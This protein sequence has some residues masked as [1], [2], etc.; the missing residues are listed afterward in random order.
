MHRRQARNKFIILLAL[1]ALL[2]LGVLGRM[3]TRLHIGGSDWDMESF[4][5][6]YI[7]DLRFEPEEIDES[8]IYAISI[9]G[10]TGYASEP[11][12]V[13]ESQS[14][15]ARTE[16][17]ASTPAQPAKQETPQTAAQSGQQ[18]PQKAAKEVAPPAAEP[19]EPKPAEAQKK[20]TVLVHTVQS[21]ETLWDIAQAYGIT[22]DSIVSANDLTNPNRLRVGQK[23]EILTVKGVLHEVSA[24]ESL[25][26][27]AQRYKV[28]IDDI[29]EVN[30]IAD[31]SRIQPKTKLIIPGATRVLRSDAL[32]VNGQLQKAFDWPV[33]GRISSSFGP[34]WGRMHNGMDIAVNT[35]TPV[36]AAA[37]G[38]VTFAGWNGGYGILVIVDH[39]NGV[40]TRYAHNSRVNV[41]V[42]QQVSRGQVV[43]YS[44][45]TG[46][47][48]GPHVHFEIRYRNNPVNP[49]LYLK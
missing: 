29:V 3:D 18:A 28:S 9:D 32:V 17:G 49:R 20:P 38:R 13:I 25:W 34:R 19:P 1:M 4:M 33:I 37:D 35:G 43:A 2:S 21:G 15:E 40:E 12:A 47:S 42:G 26:E 30:S 16:A 41:K 45:N 6:V 22:V 24:G 14:S 11:A 39:G 36:K 10:L 48:T 31:P 8:A 44:G 7:D 5:F 23:L 46:N 27:I